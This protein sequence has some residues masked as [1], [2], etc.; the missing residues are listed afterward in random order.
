MWWEIKSGLTSILFLCFNKRK[1]M[2]KQERSDKLPAVFDKA[3][4]TL[5]QQF[6]KPPGILPDQFSKP[7]PPPL[8]RNKN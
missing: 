7:S 2:N 4:G 8:I 3:P 5:P 6:S 1:K